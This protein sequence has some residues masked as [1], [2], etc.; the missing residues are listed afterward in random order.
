MYSVLA[1]CGGVEL[2]DHFGPALRTTIGGA[3][4]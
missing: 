2:I 1:D 4:T 3:G